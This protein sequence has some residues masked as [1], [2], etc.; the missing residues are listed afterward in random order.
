MKINITAGPKT[1]ANPQK[2]LNLFFFNEAY[3]STSNGISNRQSLIQGDKNE[4][5]NKQDVRNENY[6]S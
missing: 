1:R 6:I 4:V 5:Q 3:L 2:L